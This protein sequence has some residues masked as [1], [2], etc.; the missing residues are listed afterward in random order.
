MNRIGQRFGRLTVE[1]IE[2]ARLPSGRSSPKAHVVCDCGTR[3]VV[4]L[5][6][7]VGSAT[8]SCGCD[9]SRYQKMSGAGHYKFK[10]HGEIRAGFWSSCREGAHDRKIPFD[11]SIEYAWQL[12]Q[13]QGGRCVLSGVP[14]AF[15][16]GKLSNSTA[17]LDR[18][19]NAKGYVEGNIQ[20]V[21]K[22]VNIMR[23]T[24][25]VEAFFDW[26]RCVV[27]TLAHNRRGT[28]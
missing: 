7:L 21:H 28:P 10:G 2:P 9:K 27:K 14:I 16:P 19:D 18:I 6:G 23:N 8:T 1:R 13:A 17:S 4:W 11:V 3:K 25:T 5:T 22:V 12:F 26:C 15:Y 20:W 24:L